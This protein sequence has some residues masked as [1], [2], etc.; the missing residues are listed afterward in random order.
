MSFGLEGL[1]VYEQ[2]GPAAEETFRQVHHGLIVLVEYFMQSFLGTEE[3]V[4]TLKHWY[5]LCFFGVFL[6]AR[7]GHTDL[8]LWLSYMQDGH[9]QSR[10]VD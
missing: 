5:C 3:L 9:S 2:G 1:D 6:K 8:G 7:L 4:S 10:A